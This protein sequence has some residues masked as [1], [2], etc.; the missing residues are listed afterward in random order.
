MQLVYRQQHDS[1]LKSASLEYRNEST[2]KRSGHNTYRM[3]TCVPVYLVQ[4]LT[5]HAYVQVTVEFLGISPLDKPKD[6]R[7]M[8]AVFPYK[9]NHF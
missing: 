9:Q 8:T 7:K 3:S 4:R 5:G 2:K 1:D 6:T